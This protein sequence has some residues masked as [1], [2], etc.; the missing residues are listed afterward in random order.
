V[1]GVDEL[2]I[3]EVRALTDRLGD[4]WARTRFNA[5]LLGVFAVLALILAAGGVYGLVAHS[6]SQRTR[7][8][9][10]RAALGADRAG[11]LKLVVGEGMALA[12][13]GV[14]IGLILAVVLGRAVRS[15]LFEVRPADPVIL[16]LQAVLLLGT[17]VLASYLPARRAARVD[18]VRALRAE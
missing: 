1:R 9:G 14:G 12:G 5:V 3:F 18:P 10:I 7:E 6:V 11:L 8:L 15:F 4:S 17:A 16:G 13:L 2:P